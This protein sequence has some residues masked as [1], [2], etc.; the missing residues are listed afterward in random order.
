MSE[1]PAGAGP[2]ETLMQILRGI[3]D[4]LPDNHEITADDALV[5]L[6]V[7]SLQLMQVIAA[8]EHALD[9]DFPDSAISLATFESV[10]S[11]SAVVESLVREQSGSITR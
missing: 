11:L 7:T 9:L 4:D 8:V 1:S 2:T 10:G 5:D 3:L 6:G